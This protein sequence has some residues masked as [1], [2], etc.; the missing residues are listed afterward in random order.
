[1]D[2]FI[3]MAI[4]GAII[5]FVG[6]LVGLPN[7]AK[8]LHVEYIAQKDKTCIYYL[9]NEKNNR[10]ISL[11]ADCNKYKIGEKVLKQ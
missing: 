4:L 9:S 3:G 6:F 8:D 10:T 1:M 2:D 11:I 7:N 5:F